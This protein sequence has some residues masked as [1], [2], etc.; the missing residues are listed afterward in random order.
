MALARRP[1]ALVRLTAPPFGCCRELT[2]RLRDTLFAVCSTYASVSEF[3]SAHYLP[4]IVGLVYSVLF[5]QWF[6][7]CAWRAMWCAVGVRSRPFPWQPQAVGMAERVLYTVAVYVDRPL[8]VGAWLAFKGVSQW[9][10]WGEPPR[11]RKTGRPLGKQQMFMNF[12][13]GSAV[14]VAFG[15]GGGYVAVLLHDR[16]VTPAVLI[17][18]AT[19]GASVVLSVWIRLKSGLLPKRTSH[20]PWVG[21]EAPS[22]WF[23]PKRT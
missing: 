12:L 18:G 23:D 15:A 21:W 16:R 20:W 9:N 8:F 11:S 6:G 19:V 14:S 10:A 17:A 13:L 7:S 4:V 2:A 22:W 5:G 1:S 3:L